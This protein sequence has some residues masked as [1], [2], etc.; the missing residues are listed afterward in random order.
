MY[1][2]VCCNAGLLL[3]ESSSMLQCF[4]LK[5]VMR[6]N[7]E[8]EFVSNKKSWINE[9]QIYYSMVMLTYFIFRMTFPGLYSWTLFCLCFFTPIKSKMHQ[10]AYETDVMSILSIDMKHLGVKVHLE[11]IT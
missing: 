3:P 2:I 5:Q 9:S 4:K 1:V 6:E 8:I 11:Q 10:Q 7:K